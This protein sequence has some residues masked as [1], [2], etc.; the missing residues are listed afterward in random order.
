LK[1]SNNDKAKIKKEG[2]AHVEN[3]LKE[4]KTLTEE[5]AKF[6]T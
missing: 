3:F 1:E 6:D 5:K 4:K 2:D